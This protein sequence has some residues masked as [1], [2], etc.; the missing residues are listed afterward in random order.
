MNTA[1]HASEQL[2]SWPALSEGRP[3]CGAGLGLN[4]GSREIVHFHG[5]YEAD[6]HLTRSM[7]TKLR[8]ALAGS[9]AIRLS[10][11]SDWV[12][13]RLEI[14]SDVDL[15]ATLVSAALQAATRY[16]HDTAD[17]GRRPDPCTHHQGSRV[18]TVV[19]AA[20]CA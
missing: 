6:V 13:V 8:P 16:A 20:A 9:T 4:A 14:S 11:G 5:T 10:T 15:L 18:A 3:A 19:V 17:S 7:I 12:T 1:R 2:M